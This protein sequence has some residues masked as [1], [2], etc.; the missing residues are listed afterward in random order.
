MKKSLN[1]NIILVFAYCLSML[2]GTSTLCL[3]PVTSF[4][5]QEWDAA[6]SFTKQVEKNIE[7][8]QRKR[9]EITGQQGVYKA[10]F[11]GIQKK[12]ASLKERAQRAKNSEWE[13]LQQESVLANRAAQV[14]AELG[15]TCQ[16]VKETL[17][18]HIKLLQEYKADPDFKNKGFAPEQ[19]SIYSVED[20]QKINRIVLKYKDELKSLEERL[21]KAA[22]DY[23]TLKKNQTLARQEYEEKKREQKELKTKDVNEERPERKKMTLKQRG[24]LLDAEE[25]LLRLKKELADLRLKELDRKAEFIEQTIKITKL[26]IEVLEDEANNVRKELRVDKKEITAAQTVLKNQIAESNRLQQE[27]ALV[28]EGLNRF[29]HDELAKLNQLKQR[30]GVKENE[31]EAFYTW[32]YQPSSLNDWVTLIQLATI[33]GRIAFQVDVSK[34]L[35][36]AR[37]EEE[38]AK[39]TEAEINYLI[40]QTWYSLTNGVFEGYQSQEL[41]KEI[42]QYEKMKADIQ[43]SISVLA[44]KGAAAS[45]L[46]SENARMTD[47]IGA[48]MKMIK[49]QRETIFKNN[50]EEYQRL[51]ELLAEALAESQ[52][53]GE[54]IA[55]LVELYMA[56]ARLKEATIK[57]IDTMLDVL[58]SKSQWRGGPQL[59]KG[60]KKFI[61]DMTRFVQYLFD[62]KQLQQSIMH[63]QKVLANWFA[64][65]KSNPSSLF[66][67]LLYILILFIIYLLLRL[68]LPELALLLSSAVRPEHGIAYTLS[69][70]FSTVITFLARHLKG[71]YLWGLALIGVRS[72]V[73][74]PYLAVLV[75]VVSIPISIYY[76]NRFITYLKAVNSAHGYVFTTKKYQRRFFAVISIFLYAT[77]TIFFLREA[78]LKVF[79]KADAPNTLLALNF[80][81]L[82]VALILI[83]GRQQVLSLVPRTTPLWEW[84]YDHLNKYYYLFL[85]GLIFIIIMSN[86]YIGYGPIFFYA[87]T[88]LILIL[89]LIPFFTAVQNRIKQ[90]SGSFFFYSDEEG[91]KERFKHGRTLY[92]LF[93]IASFLCLTLLVIILAVNIWGYSLGLRDASGWLKKG[94]Y[95]YQHSTGRHI[96]VNALRLMGVFFYIF[97]G[98]ALAYFINTFVLKRMFDLLLVNVGVQSAIL[99]LTRYTIIVLSIF[100]GLNSVGLG[101]SLWGLGAAVVGLGIAGKEIITDFIGYFVILI[102]RPLK[103]GDF[104]RIDPELTGIVRHVTLRSIVMR[105]NNSVTVIIPNSFVLNRAVT[106]WNYSRTYFAFEDILFTITYTADPYKVKELMFDVLTRNIN[107]LKNPAPIVRLNDFSDNGFVFMVRGFLSPDKVSDQYE[108]ASDVRLEIVRTLRAHGLDVGSPTRVLRLIQEKSEK[109]I[110]T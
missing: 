10:D 42:K 109:E 75:Y 48:R 78:L 52:K 44:D 95:E 66:A 51:A 33:H 25:L 5:N 43:A 100:I 93:I 16:N 83:I 38:K 49:V 67:T 50:P 11:E 98:I 74:D 30:F 31:A 57:K 24:A 27:Y 29:R 40:V 101:H 35:Q 108:I 58:T 22:A 59:W 76:L 87:I 94:I 64:Q 71:I 97:G 73:V 21:K 85:A 20:F 3:G 18:A 105:R 102:Q 23:D 45:T 86:P 37:I 90:W 54:D 62:G 26:Q 82:Q 110:G 81:L 88:R 77:A 103:I 55:K 60:F 53:R 70:F 61:P 92:G 91:V 7:D 34:D 8:L 79:P 68:Y 13:Y 56:L 72:S 65:L 80:I 104:I 17:D 46:L 28:I 84:V 9:V 99:S 1:G 89:L 39:V 63:N 19:K 96:E 41:A 36:L 15:Q 14:L 6:Q 32:A 107:V 12:I 2:W 47:A 106:N 4:F 69:S